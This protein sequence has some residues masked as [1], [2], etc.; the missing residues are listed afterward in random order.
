[1]CY[2]GHNKEYPF[3]LRL[4]KI[5]MVML[6][7]KAEIY[8]KLSY[9]EEKLKE[10]LPKTDAYVSVHQYRHLVRRDDSGKEIWTEV[11]QAALLEN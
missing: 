5:V 7:K 11:I 3:L 9:V 6:K 2:N 10:M 4:R 8:K 1:M